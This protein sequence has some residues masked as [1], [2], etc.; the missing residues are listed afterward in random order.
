MDCSLIRTGFACLT[1][2]VAAI[3]F[4][5]PNNGTAISSC[6][7]FNSAIQSCAPG[8]YPIDLSARIMRA[9]PV[10]HGNITF[11]LEDASG[12]VILTIDDKWPAKAP[13]AGMT[14]HLFGHMRV[15]PDASN[16]CSFARVDIL[17]EG[18]PPQPHDVSP[19][20][21]FSGAVDNRLVR[22]RGTVQSISRDEIDPHFIMLTLLSDNEFV[23]ASL[24]DFGTIETSLADLIGADVFAT[25]TCTPHRKVNPRLLGRNLDI[26]STNDL[27]VVKRN[28]STA[29]T[30]LGA[31]DLYDIHPAKLHAA[32]VRRIKGTTLV[33]WGGRFALIRTEPGYISRI[34]CVQKPPE[35]LQTIEAVGT[36]VSDLF[37]INFARCRWRPYKQESPHPSEKPLD[38]TS[39]D[40]CRDAA[41][42][43]C[44]RTAFHGRLV[45]IHGKVLKE[46]GAASNDSVLTLDDGHNLFPIDEGPNEG[47]F[48]NLAAGSTI[49]VTGICALSIEDWRPTETFPRITGFT[50][51]LRTPQDLVIRTHPSWWTQKRVSIAVAVL[52]AVLLISA[53]LN[54][55]LRKLLNRRKRELEHEIVARVESELRIRER[56]RLAIE[57]HDSISQNL[58][59]VALSLRT[60]DNTEEQLP[61]N[62]RHHLDVAERTLESCRDELRYCLWDLRNDTLEQDDV[63]DAIRRTLRPHLGQAHLA[64][65]FNVAR[66]VLTDNTTHT[67]FRTIRELATNAVRHG[68]ATEIRV[69]GSIEGDNLLF[70]VSDNGCGFDA[71]DPPGVEEGHYGLL[72]VRERIE[73]AGG[74]FTI[75]SGPNG[76]KATAAL[77]THERAVH[78]N[79]DS[80]CR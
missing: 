48:R 27:V 63:S 19:E 13:A 53:T 24:M 35:A 62:I 60:I 21:L 42:R 2:A 4:A 33:N 25:G 65:R 76:T 17:S 36:P 20:E 59:G 34:E 75:V 26:S 77:P 28:D 23:Y 71:N 43:T 80:H 55:G 74:I 30:H 31:D 47:L 46:R 1:I 37:H 61:S 68:H 5:E 41:G 73:S 38:V 10:G 6:A 78:E 3:L 50:I 69:A 22:I 67:I 8:D 64:V 66:S 72:G 79:K 45:R 49:E 7:E 56:T 9:K 15:Y 18:V 57:L 52:L 70:S 32:G 39:A 12:G 16:Y 44:Y 11:T 51:I 29:F 54:I 58:T 40:I 14:V